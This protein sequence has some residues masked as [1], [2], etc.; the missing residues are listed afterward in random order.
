MHTTVWLIQDKLWVAGRTVE[1]TFETGW[2]LEQGQPDLGAAGRGLP[3]TVF[4]R[5]QPF[6]L[7]TAAHWLLCTGQ[8]FLC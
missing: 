1:Q 3:Y 6:C 4:S 8:G 5:T 2:T 7:S